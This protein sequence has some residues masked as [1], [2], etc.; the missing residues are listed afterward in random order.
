MSWLGLT[1]WKTGRLWGWRQGQAQHSPTGTGGV[2]DLCCLEKDGSRYANLLFVQLEVQ[3]R[4]TM[5][6]SQ[7]GIDPTFLE[8]V[9]VTAS[10]SNGV[11]DSPVPLV[12]AELHVGRQAMGLEAGV[13]TAF[14]HRYW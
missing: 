7:R 10:M 2:A 4:Q 5:G 11:W 3:T 13:G 6:T 8:Y 1:S 14:C 9:W 12:R